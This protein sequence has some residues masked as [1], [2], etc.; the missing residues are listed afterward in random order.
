MSI[1][2]ILVDNSIDEN[3]L[4]KSNYKPMSK[5]DL[6]RGEEAKEE[7]VHTTP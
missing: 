7:E 6:L 2:Y 4:K 3:L 1:A 5:W